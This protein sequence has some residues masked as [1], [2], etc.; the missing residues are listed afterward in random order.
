VVAANCEA[1]A[2]SGDHDRRPGVNTTWVEDVNGFA[3]SSGTV[4]GLHY[5]NFLNVADVLS[6]LAYPEQY[7]F[8]VLHGQDENMFKFV[9]EKKRLNLKG[10]DITKFPNLKA[11]ILGDIHKP[12]ESVLAY[13]EHGREI[14]VYYCGSLGVVKSDEIGTKTG[15]LYWDGVKM[16][17]LPFKHHRTYAKFDLPDDAHLLNKFIEQAAK[18]KHKPVVVVSYPD[19]LDKQHL[20]TLK[21]IEPKVYLRRSKVIK[22]ENDDEVINIRSELKTED[23]VSAVVAELFKDDDTLKLVFIDLLN[24]ADPKSVLD[25]YKSKM[26]ET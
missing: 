16:T 10:I 3:Y 17:R 4:I 19:S 22:T 8:I 6:K 7:E 20:D 2:I 11:I 12:L 26:L 1:V 14:P 23:K 25:A 15:L 13:P 18:E 24:S 5:R 21:Q 9:E